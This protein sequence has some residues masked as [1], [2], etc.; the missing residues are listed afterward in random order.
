[1]TS[2]MKNTITDNENN[3]QVFCDTTYHALPSK[4]THFKLWISVAF[5][6]QLFKTVLLSICL[7]KN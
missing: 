2:K 5:N 3:I 6:K 1:M 4:N 7:I